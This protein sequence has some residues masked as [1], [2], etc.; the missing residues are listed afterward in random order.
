MKSVYFIFLST[1]YGSTPVLLLQDCSPLPKGLCQ[2]LIAIIDSEPE[3]FNV[4]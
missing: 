2:D 4:W 3:I 1:P